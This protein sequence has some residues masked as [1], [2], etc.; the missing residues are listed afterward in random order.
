MIKN[1]IKVLD[2]FSGLGGF[3]SGFDKTFS[4]VHV[5]NC[6][7]KGVTGS[8]VDFKMDCNKFLQKNNN[9]D[10]DVVLGGPP[11]ECP[12]GKISTQMIR[13]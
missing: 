5:D 4:V 13:H 11:C 7:M 10:Y 9:L 3:T 8:N 1:K 6:S 2:L 12:N